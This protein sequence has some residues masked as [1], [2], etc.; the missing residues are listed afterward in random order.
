MLA[1]EGVRTASPDPIFPPP[2]P[3][4]GELALCSVHTGLCGRAPL[5]GPLPGT[6]VRLPGFC[7]VSGASEMPSSHVFPQTGGRLFFIWELVASFLRFVR[8]HVPTGMAKE[9]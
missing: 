5:R 7:F 6:S 3:P 9:L 8:R 4:R 2:A 1:S